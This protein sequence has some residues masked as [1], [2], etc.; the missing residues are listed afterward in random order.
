MRV[1]FN[2]A[3][4]Y[5]GCEDGWCI[6]IQ[7]KY[8]ELTQGKI[9]IRIRHG[10]PVSG[11]ARRVC[12]IEGNP[13]AFQVPWV[14]WSTYKYVNRACPLRQGRSLIRRIVTNGD[15]AI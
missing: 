4:G 5:S 9:K 8:S 11:D 10:N 2:R 3:F 1:L 6:S 13:A 14:V 15:D 12:C 7:L